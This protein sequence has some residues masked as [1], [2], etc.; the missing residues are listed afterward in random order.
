MQHPL[1]G[2]MTVAHFSLSSGSSIAQSNDS[3]SMSHTLPCPMLQSLPPAPPPFDLLLRILSAPP[4]LHQPADTL[5][6][7]VA[8]FTSA[9]PQLLHSSLIALCSYL[10]AS[11]AVLRGGGVESGTQL[12][13]RCLLL[14]LPPHTQRGVLCLLRASLPALGRLH[15]A[16]PHWSLLEEYGSQLA[17]EK[18]RPHQPLHT[19]AEC[20]CLLLLLRSI[21]DTANRPLPHSL[22]LLLLSPPSALRTLPLSLSRHTNHSS[23]QPQQLLS[24]QS[25]SADKAVVLTAVPLHTVS[26]EPAFSAAAVHSSAPPPLTPLVMLLQSVWA[27]SE[28][29]GADWT[30]VV[31][32]QQS[33]E[34][35]SVVDGD[36]QQWTT[37]W[38]EVTG[39]GAA[40]GT[41]TG[42]VTVST[43]GWVEGGEE[44]YAFD[45]SCFAALV[46]ATEVTAASEMSS[47]K[48]YKDSTHETKEGAARKEEEQARTTE[49]TEARPSFSIPLS[50]R[51]DVA[52]RDFDS[53]RSS[54]F[55]V[56]AM[57][58]L[59][60]A[61]P[62]LRLHDLL[63]VFPSGAASA[64]LSDD[65]LRAHSAL[66]AIIPRIDAVHALPSA[67]ALEIA[68]NRPSAES[69]TPAT[70][71]VELFYVFVRLLLTAA[72]SQQRAI[73]IVRHAM[74]HLTDAAQLPSFTRYTE[75]ALT[76]AVATHPHAVYHSLLLPLVAPN[77]VHALQ[78]HHAK[79][80][81]VCVANNT[82]RV[83]LSQQF[84]VELARSMIL[85]AARSPATS[86]APSV[87]PSLTAL[88][89]LQDCLHDARHCPLSPPLIAA[90]VSLLCTLA[91]LPS[92]AEQEKQWMSRVSTL[93]K[94]LMTDSEGVRACRERKAELLLGWGKLRAL[95]S[96]YLLAA[97]QADKLDKL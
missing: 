89:L 43:A 88:G 8:H 31:Q 21:Y 79:L 60:S 5:A 11:R 85:H 23:L 10:S 3:D 75:D 71:P 34:R 7:C 91:A 66:T 1:A 72:V 55:A 32:Q 42:T 50:R 54:S 47:G 41:G 9:P 63:G 29:N 80:V 70:L 4:P 81:A 92:F 45:D 62:S 76:H 73:I 61:L 67:D 87:V 51:A 86:T 56:A 48:A 96:R 77:S 30:T 65:Q 37:H 52:E 24:T 38:E 90:A 12:H 18:R 58:S 15:G 74:A 27:H 68:F 33:A 17:D 26:A 57:Q 20:D 97:M 95:K 53:P 69:L 46:Q 59:L 2:D 36:E 40:T 28:D 14:L 16:P 35:S 22:T 82:A 83:D 94:R 44:L 64:S 25:P 78:P 6:V 13:I 39:E 49:S 19:T 84:A 93:L